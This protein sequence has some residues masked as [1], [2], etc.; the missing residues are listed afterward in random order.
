MSIEI[1][2]KFF[3]TGRGTRERILALT[4]I[5]GYSLLDWRME[6]AL[7]VYRDTAGRALL[8]AGYACGRRERKGTLPSSRAP[9]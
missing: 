6:N 9:A 5:G 3:V 2:A 7:D 1:E 4:G 8:L